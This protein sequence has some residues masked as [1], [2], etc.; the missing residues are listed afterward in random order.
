MKTLLKISAIV[1]LTV[2]L[3][4][5]YTSE[6]K[7]QQ[8]QEMRAVMQKMQAQMKANPNMSKEEQK[9]IMMKAMNN[10]KTIQN[11][12]QKQ[13]V[14]MPKMLKVMKYYRSCLSDS[15][16]KEDAKVCDKKSAVKAKKLGLD[17][18]FSEEQEDFVWDKKQM[19]AE[20]DG[21][22]AHLEHVLPCI[23]KAQNM[24]DVMQCNKRE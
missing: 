6:E 14:E 15:N 8:M 1:F 9:A 13:K 24:S 7:A 18:D 4:Q 22:I 2:T 3:A 23:Q 12:L 10:S 19:L 21:G 17:R 20:I 5:A 11:R 16:S